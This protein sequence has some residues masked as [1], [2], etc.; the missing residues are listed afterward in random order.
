M[1]KRFI[2]L[3]AGTLLCSSLLT[4]CYVYTV[5]VG[6]GAKGNTEVEKWNNYVIFGLVPVG[7]SD[8]KAMA[9]GATD[10]TVTTRHSFV[11]GLLTGVTFGIYSPTTTTVKK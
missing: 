8:A 11:N 5:V 1:K 9:A 7:V 6:A 3:V 10:Y 4:S 2:Q